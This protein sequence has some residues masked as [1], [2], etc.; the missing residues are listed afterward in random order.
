MSF[1]SPKIVNQF[2]DLITMTYCDSCP[3]YPFCKQSYIQYILQVVDVFLCSRVSE[4]FVVVYL[5]GYNGHSDD[6]I[7]SQIRTNRAHASL[8][9]ICT[10]CDVE[11]GNLRTRSTQKHLA[12][13][14][15]IYIQRPVEFSML[16]YK[17]TPH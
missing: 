15:N 11:I 1:D 3:D 5:V 14:H 7:V 17:C 8:G 12:H 16:F 9:V 13:C 2:N 4:F 6:E 10:A